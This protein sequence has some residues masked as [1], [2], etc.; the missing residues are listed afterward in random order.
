V[1][2]A[3]LV[4]GLVVAL[5][6]A[7]AARMLATAGPAW[8]SEVSIAVVLGIVV[9]AAAGPTTATLAPGLGVATRRILRAGI[10]LLG[11][12]VG[13]DEVVRVGGPSLLLVVA[14]VA[15]GIL[16]ALALAR[17]ARIEPR[18][19][20]LLAVG[21]AICGNSAIIATAPIIGARAREIAYA[22]ATI[23]LFGTIAVFGY[24]VIGRMLGM[25]DET[26][27]LWVGVGVQD[28]G[29]VVAAAAAHSPG[30]L[31]VATVVKLM[32]NT[33]MAPVLLGVAWVW[34]RSQAATEDAAG[35][36]NGRSLRAAVPWFV[37]GFLAM[38]ALRT[39][40]LIGP[41]LAS[42]LDQVAR[43]CILVAVAAVGASIRF[44]EVRA[45]GMRPLG[46]GLA[47]SVMLGAAALLIIRWLG[48]S[49]APGA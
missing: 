2:I 41:E 40:G 30:A 37:L 9:A 48:M 26:V 21:T 1:T 23:T 45:A 7:A 3:R 10:V 18:L 36:P 16:V 6:A 46:V 22:V 43:A 42:V 44:G 12:R 15:F 19:A 20:V 49:V 4:P 29:Q 25:G 14:A 39:V 31:D 17:A 24:P 27:G 32:R 34:A 13:L 8:I 5:G 47:A 38:A 33:L 35:A 28:T 11:A